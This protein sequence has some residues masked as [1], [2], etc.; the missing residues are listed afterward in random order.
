MIGLKLFMGHE[1]IKLS[2]NNKKLLIFRKDLY[3]LNFRWQS[4]KESFKKKK[5][6]KKG[7]DAAPA[8]L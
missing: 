8:Y 6:D 2:F 3:V 5:V 7:H 1:K 4:I